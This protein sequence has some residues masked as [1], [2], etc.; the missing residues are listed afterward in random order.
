MDTFK[1]NFHTEKKTLLLPAPV[2]YHAAVGMAQQDGMPIEERSMA[3]TL[4]G[5]EDKQKRYTAML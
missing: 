1:H 5:L 4:C 3:T 2:T